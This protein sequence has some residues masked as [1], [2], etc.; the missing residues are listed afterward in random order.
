[1]LKERAKERK[2]TLANIATH[3]TCANCLA[4]VPTCFSEPQTTCAWMVTGK[5]L[6]GFFFSNEQDD[7]PHLSTKNS[8]TAMNSRSLV[9]D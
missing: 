3:Q 5:L 7:H 2:G 4:R 1:M 9:C 6:Q 8:S